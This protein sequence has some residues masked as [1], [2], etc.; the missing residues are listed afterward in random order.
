MGKCHLLWL[1]FF[2]SWMRITAQTTPEHEYVGC[3]KKLD[4]GEGGFLHDQQIDPAN[5]SIEACTALCR[6]K[7][8][9]FAAMNAGSTC[10]CGDKH[11]TAFSQDCWNNNLRKCSGQNYEVC[12]STEKRGAVSVYRVCRPGKYGT[13]C[14]S[15]CAYNCNGR[16]CKMMGEC[17]LECP[18]GKV[19]EGCWKPC[20]S[21]QFGPDCRYSCGE[22]LSLGTKYYKTCVNNTC[23]PVYGFCTQ[24][25][26]KIT[27]KQ[28]QLKGP[29]CRL[30]IPSQGNNPDG[31]MPLL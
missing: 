15:R 6:E 20:E 19:G 22:T 2:C 14:Q 29:F 13:R 9:A 21:D 1:W 28:I 31:P 30:R 10:L 8:F 17:L 3:F 5:N 18:A 16:G 27:S 7:S 4:A 26:N 24:G 11:Y 25:C 23:H 12:G